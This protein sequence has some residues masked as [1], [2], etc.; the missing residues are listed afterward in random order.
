[1]ELKLWFPYKIKSPCIVQTSRLFCYQPSL[2]PSKAYLVWSV[3]LQRLSEVP[4]VLSISTIRAQKWTFPGWRSLNDLTSWPRNC[5]NSVQWDISD[6]ISNNKVR[7][8]SWAWHFTSWHC[9]LMITSENSI[10]A[11]M[12]FPWREWSD[13]DEKVINH[14]HLEHPTNTVVIFPASAMWI[15]SMQCVFLECFYATPVPNQPSPLKPLLKEVSVSESQSPPLFY[16]ALCCKSFRT[17]PQQV[18]Q[19]VCCTVCPS[20]VFY[21]VQLKIILYISAISI[22]LVAGWGWNYWMARYWSHMLRKAEKMRDGLC[23]HSYQL[24]K[25]GNNTTLPFSPNSH[26]SV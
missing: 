18:V 6:D 12:V 2:H 24:S 14:Q 16:N 3:I 5:K 4:L 1:M 21:P 15:L 17:L 19:P 8:L 11:C 10:H 13:A 9:F 25:S 26:I 7:K 22:G 23:N 20:S